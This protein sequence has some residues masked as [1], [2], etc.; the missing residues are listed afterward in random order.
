L[1]TGI[2]AVES[3]HYRRSVLITQGLEG[4]SWR[5]WANAPSRRG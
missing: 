1:G 4:L 5:L 2:M 3:P